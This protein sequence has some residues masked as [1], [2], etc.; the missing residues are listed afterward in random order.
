MVK[1]TLHTDP[2][3]YCFNGYSFDNNGLLRY[4]GRIYIL[5]RA[6]L[7]KIVMEEMHSTPYSGH[8]GVTKM[9]TN[10]RPLYFWPRLKCVV[11]TFLAQCLGC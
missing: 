4:Q 1:T 9:A 7:M 6:R 2:F 8:L 11:T 3:D 5:D 10:L